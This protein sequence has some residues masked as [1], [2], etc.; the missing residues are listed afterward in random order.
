MSRWLR[1]AARPLGGWDLIPAWNGKTPVGGAY[2]Q[3]IAPCRDLS[4]KKPMP[5]VRARGIELF[6]SIDPTDRFPADRTDLQT[7][8]LLHVALGAGTPGISARDEHQSLELG[9]EHSVLVVDTCVHLDRAA[10]GL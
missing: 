2:L 7:N 3:T 6:R 4:S 1:P 5:R 10:V 9:D 8:R